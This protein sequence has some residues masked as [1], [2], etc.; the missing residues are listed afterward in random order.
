MANGTR[1]P[2]A[3]LWRLLLW[4]VLAIPLLIAATALWGLIIARS[5]PVVRAVT[6]TLAG[7]PQGARPLRLALVSDIHVGNWAMPVDRLNRIVDQINAERPDAVLIAGDLVNG[8]IPGSDQFHPDLF[9]GP[10]SRLRAPLGVFA[11]MGNHDD[12]TDPALV[13]A[14]LRR[15]GVHV[16]SGSAVRLG[17]IAL[18]GMDYAHE[19]RRQFAPALARARKLGGVPVLITHAPPSPGAVPPNVPLVLAGHTHCGQIVLG[20]WDNS[21]DPLQHEQRFDPKFRCGIARARRY[22]IVVTAG[23]GAASAIPL[24]INAPSDIWMITLMPQQ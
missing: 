8:E 21:W 19:T 13:K 1:R 23:L 6:F 14:A 2:R 18:I 20:P 17:P 16:L 3:R 24:R 10:L 11:S 4:I 15:A 5:T 22:A 12:S 7:M 9:I